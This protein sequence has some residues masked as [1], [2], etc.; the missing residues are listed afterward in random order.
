MKRIIQ[1]WGLLIIVGVI[2]ILI[3]VPKFMKMIKY[4]ISLKWLSDSGSDKADD[5][6]DSVSYSTSK[7]SFSE[8]EAKIYADRIFD[9]MKDAFQDRSP[10]EEAFDKI[11]NKD[12]MSAVYKAFGSRKYFFFGDVWMPF[13][14]EWQTLDQWLYSEDLIDNVHVKPKMEL[15]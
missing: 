14:A 8:A 1:D 3:L 13:F 2:A 4:L 15:L 5:K 10:L 6:V 9:C 7:M 11:K 12:D